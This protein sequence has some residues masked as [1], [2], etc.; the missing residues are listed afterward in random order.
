MVQEYD[1]DLLTQF[2]TI[3]GTSIWDLS[4]TERLQELRLTIFDGY[5]DTGAA[6]Q[7]L[8]DDILQ[9]GQYHY[10]ENSS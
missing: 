9:R 7:Y 2:L 1:R 10:V 8:I 4:S 5:S 6:F 3:H